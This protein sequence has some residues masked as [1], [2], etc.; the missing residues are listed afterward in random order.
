MNQFHLNNFQPFLLIQNKTSLIEI[1]LKAFE[2]QSFKR[3]QDEK[4]AQNPKNLLPA[5]NSNYA[6]TNST[7]KAIIMNDVWIEKRHKSVF[8]MIVNLHEE[9]KDPLVLV[10][11]KER[12]Q[13]QALIKELQARE[14]RVAIVFLLNRSKSGRKSVVDERRFSGGAFATH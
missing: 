5:T 6:H 11:A 2:Q 1:P 8:L 3:Q 14:G 13:D 12:E 7:P 4:N 10:H 9:H